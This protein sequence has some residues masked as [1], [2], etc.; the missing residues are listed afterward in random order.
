VVVVVV[1]GGWW[2]WWWL[3]WW[4]WWCSGGRSDKWTP[5]CGRPAEQPCAWR[6]NKSTRLRGLVMTPAL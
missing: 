1:G 5:C 3:W 6:N 4:W 2:W